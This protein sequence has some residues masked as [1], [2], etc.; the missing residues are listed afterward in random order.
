MFIICH[1][2]T[3]LM[4]NLVDDSQIAPL[5]AKHLPAANCGNTSKKEKKKPKKAPPTAAQTLSSGL[6]KTVMEMLR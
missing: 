4:I 1:V 6:E 3:Y 2:F 5:S